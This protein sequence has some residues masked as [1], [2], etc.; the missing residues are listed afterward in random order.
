MSKVGETLT[1]EQT[2]AGWKR[3]T[4]KQQR[5]LDN[6]MYRDM[7]QTASAREAGY[8]N[9][10]VDAVRLLRNPV[11][12]ERYQEMRMEANAK[13]GV[14]VEKSVRDLLKMRNEAWDNGKIGEAIRA[15]ELRLK[16]TG[17]LVN[18][19][20]VMHEDMNSLSR[21]QII[22]KLEEF[23]NIAVGRMRNVTP[24]KDVRVQ[25]VE[26][27]EQVGDSGK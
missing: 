5:F 15:E 9:P 23:K 17:L 13:F 14:T 2:K 10:T 6:F 4:A 21:E 11:V 27:S 24:D 18:K 26:S 25:I 7:T 16:A 3:L 22:E 20:H 12:Q 1:K 8:S 19:Q